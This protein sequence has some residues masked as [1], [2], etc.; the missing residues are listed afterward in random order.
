MKVARVDLDNVTVIDRDGVRHE[1][2]LTVA[3]I[4]TRALEVHLG[5][6]TEHGLLALQ[7]TQPTIE[8][9]Q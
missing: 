9:D 1:A 7:R 8:G 6:G 3:N 5:P 2:Y 4:G